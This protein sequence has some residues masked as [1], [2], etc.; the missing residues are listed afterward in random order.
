MTTSSGW[1]LTEEVAR[2][3]NTWQDELD[4]RSRWRDLWWRTRRKQS[5]PFFLRMLIPGKQLWAIHLRYIVI[6]IWEYHHRLWV[7][8]TSYDMLF[9]HFKVKLFNLL[10]LL[11]LKLIQSLHPHYRSSFCIMVL[12]FCECTNSHRFIIIIICL[13]RCY[14]QNNVIFDF[15]TQLEYFKMWRLYRASSCIILFTGKW[16]FCPLIDLNLKTTELHII[17]HISGEVIF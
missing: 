1:R 16:D 10:V 8:L 5:F 7:V 15:V 6:V 3:L 13:L 11:V 9:P 4:T 14:V 17:T 12:I 2:H